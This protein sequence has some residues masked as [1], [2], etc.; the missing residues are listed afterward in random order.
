MAA[1]NQIQSLIFKLRELGKSTDEIASD[2]APELKKGLEENISA[3]RSPDGK[4]WQPTLE[5]EAP[6]QNAGKALGVA[7][8]G[9]KVLAVVSGVEARHNYGK[10]RG[11]K[12]RQ[13]IPTKITDQISKIVQS[14]A[15]R[16]FKMIM[17]K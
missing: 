15:S 11:G 13:I 6:L 9:S 17:G 1:Y 16:R 3:A 7:A 4:A 14:V 10:V 2:I 12:V 5:G 8:I